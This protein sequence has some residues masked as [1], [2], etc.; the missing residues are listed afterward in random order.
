LC[1]RCGT[2]TEGSLCKK[3]ENGWILRY[4]YETWSLTGRGT[5]VGRCGPCRSIRKSVTK[6]VCEE[7]GRRRRYH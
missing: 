6:A 7:H 5:P 3:H 4:Y 2:N 1:G